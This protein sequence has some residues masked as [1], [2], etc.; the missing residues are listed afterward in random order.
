MTSYK[1]PSVVIMKKTAPYTSPSSYDSLNNN[2]SYLN[3]HND[4]NFDTVLYLVL[5]EILLYDQQ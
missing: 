5:I 2:Q 4:L 1:L 3:Y